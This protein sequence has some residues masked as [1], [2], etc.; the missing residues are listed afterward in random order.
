MESGSVQGNRA[1]WPQAHRTLSPNSH[2]VLQ[3]L[4]P[5][6]TFVKPPFPHLH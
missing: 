4:S 1:M 3:S 6:L 5:T 2:H